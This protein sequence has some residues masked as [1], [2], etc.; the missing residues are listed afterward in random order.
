MDLDSFNTQIFFELL[1]RQSQSVTSTLG[2]FKEEVKVVYHRVMNEISLLKNLWLK[3]LSSPGKG[4]ENEE[5]TGK[6]QVS[7]PGTSQSPRIFGSP[8]ISNDPRDS[9]PQ[10]LIPL[11]QSALQVLQENQKINLS[12]ED[13]AE[14]HNK[15]LMKKKQNFLHLLSSS[16][17]DS[18]G[19]KAHP[20]EEILGSFSRSELEDKVDALTEELVQILEDEEQFLSSEG[21]EDFLSYYLEITSLEKENL[22]KQINALEEELAQGRK[23]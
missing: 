17:R 4:E 23:M 3:A 1:L 10:K 22:V 15:W 9:I 16:G 14:P 21:N 5:N 7:F 20:E 2:R 18:L 12:P 11:L 13:P 8:E 19:H 6:Q